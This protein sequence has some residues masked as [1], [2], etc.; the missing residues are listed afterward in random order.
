[1]KIGKTLVEY[2]I[3][4]FVLCSTAVRITIAALAVLWIM[5]NAI[6]SD[7]SRNLRWI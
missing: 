3:V 7:L 4:K 1:M 6:I 2:L 5:P